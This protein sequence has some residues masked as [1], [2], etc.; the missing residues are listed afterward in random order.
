MDTHLF[1]LRL[2]A[3]KLERIQEILRQ[4]SGRRSCTRKELQSLL[5]HLSHAATVII[6][7]RMG[8]TF[9]RQ[10]FNLLRLAHQ[11]ICLNAS[12][13][14][15]LLW[16]RTFLQSWNGTS[17]FPNRTPLDCGYFGC[18]RIIWLWCL[19]HYSRMVPAGMAR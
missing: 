1:E 8:R 15:D 5:G 3:D 13:R 19:L 7:C 18:I 17:F 14:A 11:Y 12:A 16:W 9:L 4:W 6:Q 10:L 2:P